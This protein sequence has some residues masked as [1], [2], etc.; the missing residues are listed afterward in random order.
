[1][2]GEPVTVQL[3]HLLAEVTRSA[4]AV[5]SKDIV[6]AVDLPKDL[7]CVSADPLQIQQVFTSLVMNARDAMT[8]GGRLALRGQN[9]VVDELY[10]RMNVDAIPGSYCCLEVADTGHGM[11]PS[12]QDRIFEPFFTTRKAEGRAGLGLSTALGIVKAHGGFIHVYS[13]PGAGTAVKVYLP[14]TG[15][16]P[17]QPLVPQPAAGAPRSGCVLVVD[18]Q[19]AISD[20][21]SMVLQQNG[22]RVVT[23]G[24]GAAA[25]AVY[26]KGGIDAVIVDWA[27][28]VMDGEQTIAALR[29]INPQVPVI[30]SSGMLD[31]PG[32]DGIPGPPVP[33]LE[34][35]YTQEQ[36]LAALDALRIGERP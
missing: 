12:V 22:Y 25:V 14:A 35:P 3:R 24:N 4:A 17:Q 15:D 20:M 11:T 36:L 9:I 27:M 7:W 2:E 30:A 21:A 19:P 13:E 23:A 6:F 26:V 18:D 28:P 31:K 5:L 34:K 33:F 29:S 8:N 32:L 1:M 10:A 16:T